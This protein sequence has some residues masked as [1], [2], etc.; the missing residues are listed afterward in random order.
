MAVSG[1]SSPISHPPKLCTP[2]SSVFWSL[3]S[4][5]LVLQY[6]QLPIPFQ[7][8]QFH[9]LGQIMMSELCPQGFEYLFFGLFGVSGRASSIIG[10]TVIQRIIDN[11]HGNNWMGFPFLFA[12]STVAT[13]VIW[14]GVD[15]EKGRRDAA[16]FSLE[17]KPDGPH[18]APGRESNPG[19]R[20]SDGL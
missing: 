19:T 20:E 2:S 10:P 11:A 18:N 9:P 7:L 6:V 14:F 8:A 13:L 16:A 5:P 3:G 15:M 12:L 17:H 4:T 1:Y